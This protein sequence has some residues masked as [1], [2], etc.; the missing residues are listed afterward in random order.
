MTDAGREERL[1]DSRPLYSTR[2]PPSDVE[3]IFPFP[4]EWLSL[5]AANKEQSSKSSP[6]IK[7]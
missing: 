3:Q 2:R 1:F 5:H 4:P 7:S 6:P